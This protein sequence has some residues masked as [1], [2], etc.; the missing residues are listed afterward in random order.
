MPLEERTEWFRRKVMRS[1]MLLMFL[2]FLGGVAA[3]QV[4]QATLVLAATALAAGATGTL[5]ALWRDKTF[6][7]LAL[8][9]LSL[10]LYLVLAR[11][12]TLWPA[13]DLP[14]ISLLAELAAGDRART[15]EPVRHARL[16]DAL[17]LLRHARLDR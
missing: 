1:V 5:V 17:A 3:Y 10:V 7:A 14:G 13:E 12:L 6:P 4:G 8:T 16:G 9:V 15:L 2:T 11:G